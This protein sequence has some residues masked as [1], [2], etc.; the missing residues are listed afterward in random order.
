MKKRLDPQQE[1]FQ[2]I[3]N[4]DIERFCALLH[5]E[6]F[7]RKG[8]AIDVN[9][10]WSHDS[11]IH[12]AVKASHKGKLIMVDLLLK[13]GAQIDPRDTE[14]MTPLHWASFSGDL[15]LIQILADYQGDLAAVDHLGRSTLFWAFMGGKPEAFDWLLERGL[16]PILLT[17]DHQRI[18]HYLRSELQ[19]GMAVKSLDLGVEINTTNDN[20]N[21]P[22]LQAIR[23]PGSDGVTVVNFLLING[24][25]VTARDSWGRTAIMII[26]TEYPDNIEQR[27]PIIQALLEHGV[28][29]NSQD[30]FGQTALHYAVG[31]C[32]PN[33]VQ[34]LLE[35]GADPQITDRKRCTPY[36]TLVPARYSE[37][38]AQTIILMHN[39]TLAAGVEKLRAESP[40]TG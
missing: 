36:Q 28:D 14:G 25:D 24:A 29:V 1:L 13:H 8:P 10:K 22:L 2:V 18:L 27:M 4:G 40:T 11:P 5:R 31:N 23:I 38:T 39:V 35:N 20:G 3:R 33:L 9:Q 34:L 15:E 26:I 7:L 17:I 30:Q 21:T 6:T 37:S 19:I 32:L 12:E 16:S